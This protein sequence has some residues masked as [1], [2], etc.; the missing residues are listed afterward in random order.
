MSRP[1][2][3]CLPE[4]TYH[5]YSRCHNLKNLMLQSIFKDILIE[6]MK[7]TLRKYEFELIAYAILDN[8]F[9]FIIRT[10]KG[11]ESISRIMQFIKSKYA[12]KYN[13]KMNRKGAFWNERFKD[14]IVE[15][16]EDPEFYLRQLLWYLGYNP[17]RKSIVKD[18]R[19]YKYGSINY[20]LDEKYESKVKITHHE[21]FLNLG[22][23]FRERMLAF[24][25]YEKLHKI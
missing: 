5:V 18:P 23:T 22:D 21:Y 11:G 4:L 7:M 13:R 10:V 2:R 17:V 25:E 14:K 6:I 12:Q 9:H 3:E 24:I 1:Q 19:D 8:H 16:Q 20:Y 15:Y